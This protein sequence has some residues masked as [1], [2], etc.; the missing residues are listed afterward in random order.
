M[1]AIEILFKE[2]DA[3]RQSIEFYTDKAYQLIS[4]GGTLVIAAGAFLTSHQ[5]HWRFYVASAIVIA[6]FT[7]FLY[8]SGKEVKAAARRLK[9]IEAKI[10]RRAGER[11][12]EW[13]TSYGA[14]KRAT[15]KRFWNS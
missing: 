5:P 15:L 6:C 1:D 9:V 13:E 12:L 2:Y 8:T 3:L 14:D 4:I 10:N 11:L 7:R